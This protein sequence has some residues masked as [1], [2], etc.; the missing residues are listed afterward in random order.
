LLADPRTPVDSMAVEPYDG[1]G[2]DEDDGTGRA[3]DGDDADVW[4]C[5]DCG[6]VQRD[7]DPPCER[8]W[9][10][11]FVAGE[12]ADGVSGPG[13]HL[14]GLSNTPA[15]GAD[16]TATRLA[17]VKSASARTF[18]LAAGCTGLVGGATAVLPAPS[19]LSSLLWGATL[20]LGGFAVVALTVALLAHLTDTLGLAADDA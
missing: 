13:T 7:P 8:C 1:E 15:S 20:L 2:G 5:K 14:A 17:H 10:T 6:A 9:G 19:V 11:T 3:A 12:G 16:V 18:L 4:R